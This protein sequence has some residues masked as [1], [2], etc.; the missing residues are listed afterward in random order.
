MIKKVIDFLK[1]DIWRI[2]RK[3]HSRLKSL[4]IHH[5]RVVLLALRGFNEDKCQMRASALTFF[6][7][8]S[9][10]PVVAMAFG[11]AKGF[12]FDQMLVTQLQN[13]FEQQQEI[14][15]R[16]IE[17]AQK[18]LENTRGGVIAGIGVA[19][20]FWTVIKVLGNIEHSFNDIWGI[21]K[22]RPLVRK[23]SDYLAIMF[24]CPV[25]LILS[26]SLSVFITTQVTAITQKIALLGFFSP[27]IFASLKLLP[28]CVLWILFTFIYI[29]MPNT[30]VNLTAGIV[31]GVVGGTLYQLVQWAYIT[32]QVGVSK[33][34]AIYGSFAALPLFLIWLQMSWLIVLF[35]AEVSF[36]DQNADTYEFEQ[37]CMKVS[38][39]FRRIVS[40]VIVRYI[41]KEFC[42]G[43]PPVLITELTEKLDIPIRLMRQLMYD[44]VECGIL[45]EIKNN[46]NAAVAYQPARDPEAL[47]VK[48]VLDTLDKHGVDEMP[49]S[50][51]EDF[52]NLNAILASFDQDVFKSKANVLLKQL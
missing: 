13:G 49:I 32:F 40:L 31:G 28:Y 16:I 6:T 36:A 48:F 51:V 14:V 46:G 47:S 52:K 50:Q 3:R 9:I 34:G 15:D 22:P 7:L 1:Q 27:L 17:F 23:F 29:I 4:L 11:I 19:L 8:L 33:Y 26:S 20:L 38:H 30:K 37:D 10:V 24:V 45:S 18:F 35:G 39:S 43:K 41:V 25:L 42:A 21:K 44:L 12:G 5:L 2:R